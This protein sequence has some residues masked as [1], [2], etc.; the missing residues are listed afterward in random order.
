MG[1]TSNSC[2]QVGRLDQGGAG[3][4]GPARQVWLAGLPYTRSAPWTA[5]LPAESGPMHRPR[6]GCARNHR[7]FER[8]EQRHGQRLG[9]AFVGKAVEALVRDQCLGRVD[10]AFGGGAKRGVF[11]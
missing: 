2:D 1:P 6:A 7:P 11:A 8:T 9:D 4:R 3:A 5:A 10:D